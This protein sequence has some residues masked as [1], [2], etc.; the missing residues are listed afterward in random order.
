MNPW[1]RQLKIL[2]LLCIVRHI[3]CDELAL[4]F[5]VSNATI[6]RDIA[7]LKY[8]F[9]VDTSCGRY[10][11]GVW[12]EDGYYLHQKPN[13]NELNEEQT[14]VL[15][16]MLLMADTYESKVIS[17]ILIQFAPRPVVP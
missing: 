1:E 6:R 2:E 17:G 7:V 9:P 3:I 15:R 5:G 11:G 16:K 4:R 13:R 12:V 14:A 10:D 8:K